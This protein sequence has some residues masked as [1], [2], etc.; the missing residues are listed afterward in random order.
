MK[1]PERS[2]K[3]QQQQL[4]HKVSTGQAVRACEKGGQCEHVF[5][6]PPDMQDTGTT[7]DV[8]SF[9]TAISTC[10]RRGHW[11]QALT[12]ARRKS[13]WNIHWAGKKA[14]RANLT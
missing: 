12:L 3:Q 6:L 5:A 2:G 4:S 7:G 11:K 13:S 8:I 1:L 10:E 14:V 9:S